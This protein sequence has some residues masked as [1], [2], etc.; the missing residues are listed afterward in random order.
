V[1]VSHFLSKLHTDYGYPKEV[2]QFDFERGMG[3]CLNNGVWDIQNGTILKLDEGRRITHAVRGFKALSKEQIREIYGE[4]CV[5]LN[6]KWP[7]THRNLEKDAS[8]TFMTPF[9]SFK[10]AVVSQ[11]TDLLDRGVLTKTQNQLAFD[12]AEL[13]QGQEA[14]LHNLLKDAPHKYLTRQP[15][16]KAALQAL[17]SHGKLLFLCSNQSLPLV[18]LTMHFTLGADWLDSFD[19]CIPSA[20]KPLFQKSEAPFCKLDPAAKDRKGA[21]V[22]FF[23]QMSF[24]ADAHN[25]IFLEGNADLLTRYFQQL[26]SKPA[27]NVAYF[28]ADQLKDVQATSEF[29]ATKMGAAHWDA[30][31]VIGELAE[32]ARHDAALW[33]KSYLVGAQAEA[34]QPHGVARNF[35]I[36][37]AAL[38]SKYA[39]AS[40]AELGPM[41]RERSRSVV[42]SLGAELVSERPVTLHIYDLSNGL[43]KQVSMA[44]LGKQIEGVW[45]TGIVIHGKEYY[46]GSGICKDPAGM[47]PFGAPVKTIDLGMTTKSEPEI[48]ILLKTLQTKFTGTNYDLFKNNCNHFT[49]EVSKAL[50]NK[51]IP[52][53]ITSLPSD[54]MNSP[55]GASL[56]PIVKQMADSFKIKSNALF[57]KEG[58]VSTEKQKVED[59]TNQV[60]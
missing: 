32:G 35:F 2:M 24:A 33:G 37:Q 13:S 14:V 46:F 19:L 58:N 42:R 48:I 27:L 28:G 9:E 17:R 1:L 20:R 12:L 18:E 5:Y 6:L 26:L 7:E 21:K 31:S 59:Y 36:A 30:F 47:T 50:L 53:D 8:W 41:L 43:A 4:P 34:W 23:E 40:L 56:M 52:A 15:Q 39:V 3:V 51:P 57:D 29:S 38:A 55:F 11:V 22:Y 45:H 10:L 60:K 54:F 16:L 49:N 25:K 44:L